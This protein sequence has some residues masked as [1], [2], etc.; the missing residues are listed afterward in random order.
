MFVNRSATQPASCRLRCGLPV[1][2]RPAHRLR[3]AYG[4]N[5]HEFVAAARCVHGCHVFAQHPKSSALWRRSHQV[6]GSSSVPPNPSF[7]RTAFGSR[8]IQTLG[9]QMAKCASCHAD[10]EDAK[11]SAF[12]WHCGAALSEKEL[13]SEL[14]GEAGATQ[15]VESPVPGFGLGLL[16]V[17][18]AIAIA[19]SLFIVALVRHAPFSK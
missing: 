1:L 14:V 7:E 12:C 11:D 17:L 4:H 2:R 19:L 9:M 5:L 8:S 3:L 16:G 13:P 15:S 6:L 10:L 18:L